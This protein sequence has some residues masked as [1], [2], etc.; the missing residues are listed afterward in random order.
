M[1]KS[2][3]KI[4]N[5]TQKFVDIVDI[6][7]DIVILKGGTACLVVEVQATNFALLSPEEQDV[8]IYSYAALLNSLSFPI[9]IVI[10]SKKLNVSNY[11]SLLEKEKGLA[12]NELLANQIGLYKDFVEQLVKVNTILDKKFYIIISYSSLEKGITGASQQVGVSSSQDIFLIGAK[13]S[14]H[15]KAESLH[16]QIRRLSLKAETLRKERLIKLFY[17]IFNDANISELEENNAVK[18]QVQAEQKEVQK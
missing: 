11:L 3:Q 10:R 17:E 7:D 6:I 18:P 15:S 4:N 9:Q 13:A 14:L 16:T 8:K 2:A 5:T 1:A 12:K